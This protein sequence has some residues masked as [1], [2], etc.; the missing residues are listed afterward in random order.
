MSESRQEHQRLQQAAVQAA[1]QPQQLAE[2]ELGPFAA[3]LFG[4]KGGSPSS[5][6]L[7]TFDA[8]EPRPR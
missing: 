5:A 4:G 3:I 1:F 8:G 7:T 2:G 6:T